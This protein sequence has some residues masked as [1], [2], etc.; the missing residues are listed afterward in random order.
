MSSKKALDATLP[1]RAF[2][3]YAGGYILFLT[4]TGA[5]I[6][7]GA[8]GLAEGMELEA[9]TRL[10]RFLAGILSFSFLLAVA[11]GLVAASRIVGLFDG[12][13]AESRRTIAELSVLTDN[14]AHDLRTPLT[15]LVSAAELAA[16]GQT[17]DLPA[18]VAEESSSMLAMINTMLEISQS[19][20]RIERSGRETLDIAATARRIVRLSD[21]KI[22]EDHAQEVDWL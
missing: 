9:K 20:A 19:G 10:F 3:V 4:V 22:V 16:A 1:R 6:L 21:G 13:F 7:L 18:I 14:I 8:Y 17:A 2:K 11:M 12:V 5:L 15:H